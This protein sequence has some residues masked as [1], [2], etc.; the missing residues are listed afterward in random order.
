MKFIAVRKR[1]GDR[2]GWRFKIRRFVLL[3]RQAHLKRRYKVDLVYLEIF[4]RMRSERKLLQILA[5]Q[6]NRMWM[7]VRICKPGV[8]V[9][10]PLIV[11]EVPA[12]FV[13]RPCLL[14]TMRK[15]LT[16]GRCLPIIEI[17]R[18]G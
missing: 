9:S 12:F 1:V 5:V 14:K 17:I 3:I 15:I 13:Q 10:D 7:D 8:M 18:M 2:P 11:A 4:F 6:T 16:P